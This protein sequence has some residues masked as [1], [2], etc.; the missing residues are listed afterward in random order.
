MAGSAATKKGGCGKAALV[1][2]VVLVAVVLGLAGVIALVD[3][4][5]V[6]PDSNARE[7]S[8]AQ[9]GDAWPLTLDTI[10]LT[11]WCNPAGRPAITV[12]GYDTVYALND[13][14]VAFSDSEGLGWRSIAEVQATDPTQ[15]PGRLP[16]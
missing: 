2:L 12:G 4:D 11:A 16:T 3:D 5:D 7:V 15:R 13:S 14:A 1:G 10:V 9:L 8:A 6:R